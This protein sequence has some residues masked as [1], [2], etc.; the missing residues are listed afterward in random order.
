[1]YLQEGAKQRV[2]RVLGQLLS[3]GY[4]RA[5]EAVFRGRISSPQRRQ[6]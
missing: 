2:Q 3:V 6:K 5:R 1:M 4:P